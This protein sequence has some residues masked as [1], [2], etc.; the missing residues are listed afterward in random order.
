MCLH[1]KFEMTEVMVFVSVGPKSTTV[2]IMIAAHIEGF[3]MHPGVTYE[4]SLCT[5]ATNFRYQSPPFPSLLEL[6]PNQ[7]LPIVLV[8][9]SLLSKNYS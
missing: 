1:Q 2:F 5:Y 3:S 7:F 8:A 9:D 4:K 6:F